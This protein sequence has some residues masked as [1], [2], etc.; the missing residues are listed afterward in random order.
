MS[1]TKR[2]LESIGFFD[3]PAIDDHNAEEFDWQEWINSEEDQS[4][5]DTLAEES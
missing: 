4:S 3:E 5:D 2:Y 1:M